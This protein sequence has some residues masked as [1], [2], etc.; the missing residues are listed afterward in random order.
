LGRNCVAGPTLVLFRE[1]HEPH[2]LDLSI[3]RLPKLGLHDEEKVALITVVGISG[4]SQRVT[5]NRSC[6]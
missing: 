1:Y 3:P 6:D 5:A 2:S 4:L